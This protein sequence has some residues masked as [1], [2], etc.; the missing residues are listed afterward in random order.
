[1]TGPYGLDKKKLV[2]TYFG[3]NTKSKLDA[4]VECAD[5]WRQLGY[6]NPSQWQRG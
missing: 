5:V 6:A 3:G 1:M 4:D 2:V